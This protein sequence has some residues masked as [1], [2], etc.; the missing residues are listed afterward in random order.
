MRQ[1]MEQQPG[2]FPIRQANERVQNRVGCEPQRRIR[3]DS[4]NMHFP[5][6]GGEAIGKLLRLRLIVIASVTNTA[7]DGEAPGIELQGQLR[8]GKHVPDGIRPLQ[9]GITAIAAVIGQ[10]EIAGSE[11][12]NFLDQGQASTQCRRGLRVL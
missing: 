9:I 3:R 10:P 7:H 11:R 8:R 12:A 2:E 4:T 6:L 5:P 1:F